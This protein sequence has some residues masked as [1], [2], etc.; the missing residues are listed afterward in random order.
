MYILLWLQNHGS[1][2]VAAD[3]YS[4][5]EVVSPGSPAY[6]NCSY[7]F[8]SLLSIA[9]TAEGITIRNAKYPLENAVITS[10]YQFG[11]SN[12]PLP[13]QTA[14]VML[15]KGYLLLIKDR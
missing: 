6:I 10:E 13:D 15:R 9:G 12:E 3:D 11:V 8:F 4:E 1:K 7:S 14:E 5:F 2:A